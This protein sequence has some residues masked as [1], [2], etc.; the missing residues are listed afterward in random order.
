MGVTN[1]VESERHC[2]VSRRERMSLDMCLEYWRYGRTRKESENLCIA[3]ISWLNISKGADPHDWIIHPLPMSADLDNWNESFLLFVEFCVRRPNRFCYTVVTWQPLSG[4]FHDS[5]L[6]VI[7]NPAKSLQLSWYLYDPNVPFDDDTA[8]RTDPHYMAGYRNFEGKINETLAY[9]ADSKHHMKCQWVETSSTIH[10]VRRWVSFLEDVKPDQR[11]LQG[12]VKSRYSQNM[13]TLIALSFLM[14][15]V[16]NPPNIC[17]TDNEHCSTTESFC[18]Y[19]NA[20]GNSCVQGKC[21]MNK[22]E[23]ALEATTMQVILLH[24]RTV[25][26]L[27]W[28]ENETV[29]RCIDLL[30][31]HWV[32]NHSDERGVVFVLWSDG[33]YSSYII[34]SMQTQLIKHYQTAKNNKNYPILAI[35]K[36]HSED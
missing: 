34:Q 36:N 31:S 5:V 6:S 1:S 11:Y 25:S 35:I 10:R 7:C 13:C 8:D 18:N 16:D 20:L 15:V 32:F 9:I 29:E 4:M 12:L 14:Y 23:K 22:C 3:Y 30:V 2:V 21:G 27:V 28:L 24:N 33:K 17:H 26:P 19:M